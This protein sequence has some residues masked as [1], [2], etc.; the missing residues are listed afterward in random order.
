MTKQKN[1]KILILKVF[2]FIS[3]FNFFKSLLILVIFIITPRSFFEYSSRK[4]N[5]QKKKFFLIQILTLIF[6]FLKKLN[7][8]EINLIARGDQ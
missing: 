2:M 3:Y 4:K 1:F 7:F 6:K 5:F 8:N